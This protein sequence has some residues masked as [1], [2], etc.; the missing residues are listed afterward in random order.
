VDDAVKLFQPLMEMRWDGWLRLHRRVVRTPEWC[1][2]D[3]GPAPHQKCLRPNRIRRGRNDCIGGT[4]RQG[5]AH[6]CDLERPLSGLRWFPL[7]LPFPRW[8]ASALRRLSAAPISRRPA[9]NTKYLLLSHRW[10]AGTSDGLNSISS[11]PGA[12]LQH[13]IRF[14]G[15]EPVAS[16]GCDNSRLFH[17][18]A[19]L[20]PYL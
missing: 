18:P 16:L 8:V 10:A 20:R 7:W 13:F 11:D 6:S 3:T 2:C 1:G 9:T 4:S 12:W 5:T 19:Q 17:K 15:F 14:L